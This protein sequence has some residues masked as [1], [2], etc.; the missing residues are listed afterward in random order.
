MSHALHL[1]TMVMIELKLFMF[2]ICDIRVIIGKEK[3][4]YGGDDLVLS[5]IF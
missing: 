1:T 3:K 4:K 2:H 5:F